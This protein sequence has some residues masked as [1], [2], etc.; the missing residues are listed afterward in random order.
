[1]VLGS[2]N[3]WSYLPVKQWYFKPFAFIGRCQSVDIKTQYEYYGVRCFDLR[4][5]FDDKGNLII[6]HGYAKYKYSYADLMADLTYLDNKADCYVRVIHEART[7]KQYNLNSINYFRGFCLRLCSYFTNIKFWC[8]RNLY[9]FE[10]DYNFWTDVSC[11]EN[12]ASV[13]PPKLIDDWIPWLY[14]YKHNNDIIKEGT[15]KDILLIDFVN[16]K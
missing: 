11:D 15:D 13:K 5:R 4:I 6:A 3:S 14:A 10:I 8:G 16:L 12:H 1:M 7:M 9:D 2:H